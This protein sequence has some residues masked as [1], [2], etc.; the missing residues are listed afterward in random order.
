MIYYFRQ[1]WWKQRQKKLRPTFR[2]PTA[3]GHLHP[4]KEIQA[5][6]FDS[7]HDLDR[8][9][10]GFHWSWFHSGLRLLRFRYPHGGL[11]HDLLWCCQRHLQSSV[12]NDN[13][14]Y[15]KSP[16][17][18]PGSWNSWCLSGLAFNMETA[19]GFSCAFLHSIQFVGC[20]W[21]CVADASK[22]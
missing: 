2:N 16:N 13:E 7:D 12:R 5:T 17:Y 4:T 3:L 11:R 21:C 6:A 10:A 14:I 20:W 15:W 1:I 9:G 8:H 19:S 18:D 22:R